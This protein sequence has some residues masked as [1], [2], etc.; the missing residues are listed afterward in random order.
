VQSFSGSSE[1]SVP[2]GQVNSQGN[3]QQSPQGNDQSQYPSGSQFQSQMS[4][5]FGT[6]TSPTGLTPLKVQAQDKCADLV[7]LETRLLES[8]SN[9]S[10]LVSKLQYSQNKES[11][12]MLAGMWSDAEQAARQNQALASQFNHL[13]IQKTG[14]YSQNVHSLIVE[15]NRDGA[16]GAHM[17]A[18]SDLTQ[19]NNLQQ[20]IYKHANLHGQFALSMLS[21]L[22]MLKPPGV[23]SGG[24]MPGSFT[25]TPYVSSGY[26]ASGAGGSY[27][28]AQLAQESQALDV[29]Y[30]Q[31]QDLMRR[32]E[33]LRQALPPQPPKRSN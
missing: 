18:Y 3:S 23:V 22:N 4:Q 21:T 7:A 12:S 15:A 9:L 30:A 1:N 25:G 16:Y 13:G 6:S 17:K 29:E 19:G 27:S 28:G 5:S 11:T 24:T 14:T 20:E 2:S 10:G 8:E 32:L 31:V 26:A 33:I